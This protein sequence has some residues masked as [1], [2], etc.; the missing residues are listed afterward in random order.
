MFANFVSDLFHRLIVYAAIVTVIG[1]VWATAWARAINSEASR[2][3]W[4]ALPVP[5]RVAGAA[6]PASRDI[7]T[8]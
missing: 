1:T 7:C 2:G 5:Q 6:P 8:P 3:W 4:P